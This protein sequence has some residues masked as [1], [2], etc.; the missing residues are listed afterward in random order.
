MM[1]P[2]IKRIRDPKYL[3]FCRS[4][5]CC[6]CGAIDGIQPHHTDSGG[7]ALVGDD[8][9]AVPVCLSCHQNIHQHHSK[10]GFW[11]ESE[12]KS[13]LERLHETYKGA[14]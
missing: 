11:K 10:R 9:S 1:F 6:I 4:L 13:L 14:L 8:T 12:L 3:K 7:V 2:K 5:P